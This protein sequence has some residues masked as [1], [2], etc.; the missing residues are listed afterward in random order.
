MH[1]IRPK[2][3]SQHAN[4]IKFSERGTLCWATLNQKTVHAR[5]KLST[6][7]LK[8]VTRELLK[9]VTGNKRIRDNGKID[10]SHVICGL[11]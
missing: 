10:I 1:L 9:C 2:F 6:S 11:F 5:Y 3:S 7:T 4:M 8:Q